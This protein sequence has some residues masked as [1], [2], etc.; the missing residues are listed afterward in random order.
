M[1]NK[2]CLYSLEFHIR[3][4][5]LE[6]QGGECARDYPTS[7]RV[8]NRSLVKAED[9]SF[10]CKADNLQASL[11]E[12]IPSL[13]LT[14]QLAGPFRSKSHR[15]VDNRFRS[16]PCSRPGAA[17]HGARRKIGSRK[18][19]ADLGSF[20]SRV[21]PIENAH[22]SAF[23]FFFKIDG[24]GQVR[25]DLRNAVRSSRYHP[26][27]Q[28]TFHLRGAKGKKM[29]KE[30]EGVFREHAQWKLHARGPPTRA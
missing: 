7:A 13:P 15:C 29:K 22:S 23:F 3:R 2:Q 26:R 19:T 28:C 21:V 8:V 10:P 24:I 30:P 11:V 1:S 16:R 4:R 9:T 25:V 6:W 14:M 27:Y 17:T 20:L 5:F 12:A 18:P